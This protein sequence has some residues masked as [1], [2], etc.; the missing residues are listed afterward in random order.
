MQPTQQEPD[1]SSGILTPRGRIITPNQ[2][3]KDL[4]EECHR[5]VEENR[6][7]ENKIDFREN[8]IEKFIIYAIKLRNNVDTQDDYQ[9]MDQLL[10]EYHQDAIDKFDLDN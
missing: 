9:E 6:R 2:R 4:K 8:I 10:D 5:L 7:L 1:S 3:I